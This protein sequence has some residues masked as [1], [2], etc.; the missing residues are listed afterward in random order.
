[1]R[2]SVFTGSLVLLS[3]LS[4]RLAVADNEEQENQPVDFERARLDRRLAAKPSSGP[5]VI[6][7]SLDET[8][9]RE[10]PVAS[11]FLQ[12]DPEEGQ[13]VTYPTEVRVLY[14]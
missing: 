4:G 14:D 6:D 8:D 12:S 11:A 5:I 7:S 10:A 3:L 9:W 2:V 1:M 13:P